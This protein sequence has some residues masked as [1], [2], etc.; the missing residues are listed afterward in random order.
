LNAGLYK[1]YKLE[2]MK[3]EGKMPK[4]AEVKY[5][6]PEM[7][8]KSDI[9]KQFL[10]LND[11]ALAYLKSREIT[12]IDDIKYTDDL[13]KLTK[14]FP[15]K[16][17]PEGERI[18]FPIRNRR[19]E[20]VGI[21]ARSINPANKL[22]YV[23]LKILNEPLIFGLDKVDISKDVY[24]LEGAIDS[25]H[26]DN[27]IAVNGSDL[28]KVSEIIPKDRQILVF[29][30][31]PRNREIVNKMLAAC[32]NGYRIVIWPKNIP[33][34]DVNLMVRTYGLA[35]VIEWLGNTYKG[36]SCKVKINDWKRI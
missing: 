36:M 26:L 2:K 9:E 18:I 22:R 33:E 14:F 32:D 11:A 19:K 24:V 5:V 21:S 20:L 16:S 8:V 7:P 30:N 10:P 25:L 17:L 31:Q 35:K 28:I 6:K 15:D 34:K 27:A 23:L 1:Q 13:F 12:K 29:D 3:T 4:K